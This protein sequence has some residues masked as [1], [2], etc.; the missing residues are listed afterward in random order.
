MRGVDVGARTIRL[1]KC[2]CVRD[3]DVNIR[4]ERER[5]LAESRSNIHQPQVVAL[6]GS[7]AIEG[8]HPHHPN[9]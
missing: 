5:E 8:G 2:V 6:G 1:Y 9:Q 7:A 3:S 4:K